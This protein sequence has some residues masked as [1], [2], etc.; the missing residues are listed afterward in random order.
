VVL[1]GHSPRQHAVAP[2]RCKIAAT[3]QRRSRAAVAAVPRGDFLLSTR[4]AITLYLFGGTN[5]QTCINQFLEP[6]R[7]P[8]PSSVGQDRRIDRHLKF[9]RPLADVVVDICI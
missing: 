5:R 2:E 6:A 9:R 8:P 7:E 3:V 1:A 4:A